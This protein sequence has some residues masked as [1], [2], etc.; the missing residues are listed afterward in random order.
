MKKLIVML[1][2]AGAAYA[3]Y[4]KP[5]FTVNAHHF[6]RL[7]VAHEFAIV[8]LA[9]VLLNET[10]VEKFYL[11]LRNQGSGWDWRM[12]WGS[13]SNEFCRTTAWS[14]LYVR[15]G[16]ACGTPVPL[17]TLLHAGTVATFTIIPSVYDIDTTLQL[18]L[19]MPDLDYEEV[20]AELVMDTY[21]NYTGGF[22]GD[23]LHPYPPGDITKDCEVNF[24]DLVVIASNWLACT[25]DCEL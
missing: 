18:V 7:H 14:S 6:D 15:S 24:D 11:E 25:F 21:Y 10:D 22:C 8:L 2:L 13:V 20:V 9:D 23:G 19:I 4:P 5:T 1:M 17:P 12:Q 3:G 16:L